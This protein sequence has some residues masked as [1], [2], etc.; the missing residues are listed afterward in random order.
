M[1][2]CTM[3]YSVQCT[4]HTVRCTVYTIRISLII[5]V[6]KSQSHQLG[7]PTPKCHFLHHLAIYGLSIYTHTH[8]KGGSEGTGGA[9]TELAIYTSFWFQFYASCS[10]CNC[11]CL[12]V[13]DL[14]LQQTS[15]SN[16]PMFFATKVA[17]SHYVCFLLFRVRW[18]ASRTAC[19]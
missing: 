12:C 6:P 19:A 13:W 9:E 16:V 2:K 7:H 15:L 5:Q 4:G 8:T 1:L 3:L 11:V 10:V 18:F 14:C 17:S